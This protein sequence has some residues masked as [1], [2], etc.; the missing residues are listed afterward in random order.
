MITSRLA[1]SLVGQANARVKS[2]QN[3]FNRPDG[4]APR[5]D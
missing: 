2:K 1:E 3:Y 4:A 5:L